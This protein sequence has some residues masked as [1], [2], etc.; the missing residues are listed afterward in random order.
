MPT[1]TRII[2]ERYIKLVYKAA[3]VSKFITLG[4]RKYLMPMDKKTRKA[5][6][7]LAKPYPKE[8]GFVKVDYKA[9][10]GKSKGMDI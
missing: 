3:S 5:I 6:L 4:K 7:P 9:M 10:F 2:L 1:V 8:E